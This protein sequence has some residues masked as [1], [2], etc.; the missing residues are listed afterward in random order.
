MHAG[1]A[2]S[3][4]LKRSTNVTD[5][6]CARQYMLLLTVT[7]VA[8]LKSNLAVAPTGRDMGTGG[9]EVEWEKWWGGG[10][11]AAHLEDA[12]DG[13][14]ACRHCSCCGAS[15]ALH[16]V[17]SAVGHICQKVQGRWVV[18]PLASTSSKRFDSACCPG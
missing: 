17:P 1:D 15:A 6:C 14:G 18:P 7:N 11:V 5:S 16:M 12:V 8:M 13:L 4:T 9:G 2:V 10:G 3:A